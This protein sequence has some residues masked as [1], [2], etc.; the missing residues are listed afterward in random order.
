MHTSMCVRTCAYSF[1]CLI[2]LHPP[3][4]ISP[5]PSIL[6]PASHRYTDRDRQTEHPHSPSVCSDDVDTFSDVCR[7]LPL[8]LSLSLSGNRKSCE[9]WTLFLFVLRYCNFDYVGIIFVKVKSDDF[10]FYVIFCIVFIR[11]ES[12]YRLITSQQFIYNPDNDQFG[13]ETDEEKDTDHS[14]A[15]VAIESVTTDLMGILKTLQNRYVLFG[16]ALFFFFD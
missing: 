4:F 15:R 3:F 9:L 6:P 10:L 11:I 14:T 2:N 13:R 16:F 5:N 12:C 8:A 7:D 1:L